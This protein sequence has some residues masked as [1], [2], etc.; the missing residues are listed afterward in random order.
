MNGLLECFHSLVLCAQKQTFLLNIQWMRKQW[1]TEAA[2][3][4]SLTSQ[5]KLIYFLG[6]MSFSFQPRGQKNFETFSGIFFTWVDD[7]RT[8]RGQWTMRKMLLI[9]LW[10]S[11]WIL[12]HWKSV[13][14]K[15]KNLKITHFPF[16]F[17]FFKTLNWKVVQNTWSEESILFST[18]ADFQAKSQSQ[19]LRTKR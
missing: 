17:F 11:T 12:W 1:S 18:E 2:H 6:Q 7:L 16:K 9:W 3:F 14:R 8:P 19:S 10:F 5:L 13:S 4:L 15:S